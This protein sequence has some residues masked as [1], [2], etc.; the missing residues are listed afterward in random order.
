MGRDPGGGKHCPARQIRIDKTKL[1]L[2]P[3][4]GRDRAVRVGG[5]RA[6]LEAVSLENE[7]DSRARG[8]VGVGHDNPGYP[9]NVLPSHHRGVGVAGE[10][11]RLCPCEF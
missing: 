7:A 4:Y 5:L 8:Q 10:S 2:L 6:D 1:G 3:Q 9:R 11:I